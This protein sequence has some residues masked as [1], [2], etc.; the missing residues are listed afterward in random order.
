MG[1]QRGPG[2]APLGGAT[3]LAAGFDFHAFARSLAALGASG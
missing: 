1:D 2:V 3:T